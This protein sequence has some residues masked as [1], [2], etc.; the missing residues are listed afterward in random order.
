MIDFEFNIIT[1]EIVVKN[2]DFFETNNPSVQY[3][4]IIEYAR[5]FNVYFPTLGVGIQDIVNSA[6]N[7]L[8][9]LMNRWKQ[10]VTSDGAKKAKWSYVTGA[11]NSIELLTQIDYV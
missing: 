1:R 5:A 3:G 9:F 7:D 10:Q 4:G 2:G 6:T 11:G 8:A